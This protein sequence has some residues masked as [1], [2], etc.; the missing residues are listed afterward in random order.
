MSAKKRAYLGELLIEANIITQEQLDRALE[1]QKKKG[2]MV[3]MILVNQGFLSEEN[4]AR[5]VHLQ[6]KTNK[7]RGFEE[8]PRKRPM[9]GELLIEAG[10]ITPGQLK[11]ALEY[12]KKSNVKIGIALLQK[13]YIDKSTLVRHLTRQA[14]TVIDHMAQQTVEAKTMVS[15]AEKR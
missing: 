9:L 7:E 14:Q 12:Q 15:E 1:I 5:Y 4:L 6:Q 3:G 13:G 11:D 10:E 8:Q 2:G